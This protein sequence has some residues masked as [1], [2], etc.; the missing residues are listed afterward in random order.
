MPLTNAGMRMSD[1]INNV[2]MS[3]DWDELKDGWMAFAL[4]DGTSDGTVY[5]TR[6]DA[7]RFH[8]NRAKKYFYCALRQC[9]HGCSQ[10]EAT[11]IL[12][13]TRVQSERGRYHPE[14]DRHD[15]IVPLTRDAFEDELVSTK[16]GKSFTV[17]DLGA[18]LRV[19]AGT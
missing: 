17:P 6:D 13:L 11:M 15:P 16:L 7:I 8:R 18:I 5:D 14:T 1:T 2:R 9:I 12:A 19:S 4:E 10:R 3:K